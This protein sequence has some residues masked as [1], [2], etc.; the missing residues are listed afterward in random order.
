MMMARVFTA[1]FSVVMIIFPNFSYN[2]ARK[3]E[4]L[5]VWGGPPCYTFLLDSLFPKLNLLKGYKKFVPLSILLI[6][7]VVTFLPL[8]ISCYFVMP[9]IAMAFIMIFTICC[10][11]IKNYKYLNG[12][13]K[14]QLNS[15]FIILIVISTCLQIGRASCRERV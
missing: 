12:E 2:V 5:L 4:Y 13:S 14:R 15:L 7:V 9:F 3:L 6:G 8:S 1:E 11:S 10:S